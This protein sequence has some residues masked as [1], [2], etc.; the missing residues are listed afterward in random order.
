MF[1]NYVVL[2]VNFLPVEFWECTASFHFVLFLS[3]SVQVGGVA[4]DKLFSKTW[5]L[6][7]SHWGSFH[8]LTDILSNL[9]EISLSLLWAPAEMAKGQ[10]A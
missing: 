2:S 7:K 8:W 6:C 10:C 5:V 4:A 1:C 9:S 3:L